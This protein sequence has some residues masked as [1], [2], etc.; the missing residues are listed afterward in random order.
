V[1][2]SE[3]ATGG[4]GPLSAVVGD[5]D[6]FLTTTLGRRPW[7]GS[8]PGS[9]AL[10]D[11]D[12]VDTI[13]S[14]SVRVPAIRMVRDGN[15]VPSLEFCTPTRIGST[16][17]T[18]TA[19]ARKVLD[20]YRRGAT[21]VLQS[22]QRTWPP[23]I[24]WCCSL[25]A[26]LGWPVQAN[27]YLT[28]AQERGLER[29]AD[30]HDVLALQLHGHK[31]WEVDGLGEFALWAGD[32]LYVPAGTEHVAATEDDPSLHLTIGIHRPTHERIASSALHLAGERV[33]G[34]TASDDERLSRLAVE[35]GRVGTTEAIDRLRRPARRPAFGELAG[36]IRRGTN[37]A[38][39]R[40][41]TAAA[42][43]L[44][45]IDDRISLMWSGRRLHLPERAGP[46]LGQLARLGEGWATVGELVGLDDGE[47]IVLARRLLDEGAVEAVERPVARPT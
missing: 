11:V 28:P 27:A 3:V 7:R 34:G 43:E 47:R 17:L 44:D 20:L 21:L 26:E 1:I 30:G 29:H 46:A 24:E 35:F 9:S 15:R 8:A 16:T 4:R 22:L 23:L 31:R 40:I 37:D 42:W 12:D 38:T 32:V 39:T 18:D 10:F 5:G 19:D 25:E 6:L 33:A 41:R 36:S 14:S 2:R 45:A 13:V